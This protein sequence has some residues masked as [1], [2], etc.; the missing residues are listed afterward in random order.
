MFVANFF[1]GQCII[2]LLLIHRSS[3]FET[4]LSY[5]VDILEQNLLRSYCFYLA[6]RKKLIFG[7]L[8]NKVY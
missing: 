3:C 7:H 8:R 6:H 4:A 1:A 5:F 2:L